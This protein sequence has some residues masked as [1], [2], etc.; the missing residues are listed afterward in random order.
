MK[1]AKGTKSFLKKKEKGKKS[2]DRYR[3]LSEEQKISVGIIWIEI[4]KIF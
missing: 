2:R 4:Q 1:L 3:N